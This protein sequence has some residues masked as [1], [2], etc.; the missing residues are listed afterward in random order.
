MEL[1]FA[2]VLDRVNV[3]TIVIIHASCE[4]LFNLTVWTFK[5]LKG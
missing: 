1:V 4:R 3:K 2:V 5:K